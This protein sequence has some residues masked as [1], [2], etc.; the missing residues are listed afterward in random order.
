MDKP[1]FQHDC[2]RCQFMRHF[3]GLDVYICRE[4]VWRETDLD[5]LLARASDENS[6]Y[7][8]LHRGTFASSVKASIVADW[9]FLPFEVAVLEAL[10]RRSKA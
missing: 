9:N 1:K 4:S 5:T 10:I 3:S 8:S 2:T 7:A 6:D